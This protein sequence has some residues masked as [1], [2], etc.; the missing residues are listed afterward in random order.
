MIKEE[1]LRSLK[2]F[3]LEENGM[4]HDNNQYM[5]KPRNK[6]RKDWSLY[7]FNEVNGDTWFIKDLFD[8]EDLRE[9]FFLLTGEELE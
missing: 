5:I 8:L 2:T 6:T 3:G 4:F 1:D 7:E 9:T